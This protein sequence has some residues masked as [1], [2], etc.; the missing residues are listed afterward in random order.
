MIVGKSFSVNLDL[1]QQNLFILFC[2]SSAGMQ[3]DLNAPEMSNLLT[4]YNI[5][6]GN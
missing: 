2:E 5:R 1:R 6:T 3:L 4:I